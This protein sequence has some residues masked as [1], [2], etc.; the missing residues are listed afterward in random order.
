MT[1][2]YSSIAPRLIETENKI[3]IVYQQNLAGYADYDGFNY[4]KLVYQIYDKK[5]ES[6]SEVYVLDDNGYADG[7]FDVWTDGENAAIVYTQLDRRLNSGNE[8]DIS[9]YVAALEVKTAHL[10]DGRFTVGGALTDDAY[11]DLSPRIGMVDGKL[12]ALWVRCE[13]NNMLG[14]ASEEAPSSVMYSQY[15]NGAWSEAVAAAQDLDTVCS[16]E[17]C[18]DSVIYIIDRNNDLL[19]A[20]DG[21]DSTGDRCVYTCS[22]GGGS[23][24]ALAD[25]A[26][27]G[28]T[29][30]DGAPAYLCEN[31]LYFFDGTP[32]LAEGTALPENYRML[33]GEDGRVRAILYTANTEYGEDRVGSNVYGIF[34]DGDRFGSPV[35]LT[36]LGADVFVS[37]FDAA[38]MGE[39]MLLSILT[40]SYDYV[41][42]GEYEQYTT[43]N[44]FDVCYMAYPCGYTLGNISYMPEGFSLDADITAT[45]EITNN[46]I[47]ALDALP[48]SV[49]RGNESFAVTLDG[50][51]DSEGN[52]IGDALP[53]GMT[54]YLR[55]RFAPEGAS[56]TPY[57][58]KVDGAEYCINAW[59]SDLAVFGK[60][61]IVGGQHR[62]IV[63]VTNLGY[64]ESAQTT[65][66][67]S[68]SDES[69][70]VEPLARGE[71]QYFT[72]PIASS[73]ADES[74]LVTLTLDADGEH[75]T[76][77]NTAQVLT[78]PSADI[79]HELGT[80]GVWLS[81]S[82]CVIDRNRMADITI[83]YDNYY[84]VSSIT[85]DGVVYRSDSGAYTLTDGAILLSGAYFASVLADGTY[86][87][88]V[89]FSDGGSGAYTS[90]TEL[91]V[92][93]F[94]DVS[95]D[96]DGDVSVFRTEQGAMPEIPEHVGKRADAQYTYTFAGW[97]ADGDGAADVLGAAT[98][99]ISYVAIYTRERNSYTVTWM[100]DGERYREE[101]AYGELPVF[102][103]STE[104]HSDVRVYDF[105]GWSKEITAV[106]GNVTYVAEYSAYRFGDYDRD[107]ALS[108]VD[109]TMLVRYLSG[110]NMEGIHS[111]NG[112][113]S[114]NNRDAIT[115]IQKLSEWE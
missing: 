107:G 37:S 83:E 92:T 105:A 33:E 52:E 63:N 102:T 94:Y 90:E 5:T 103:G 18:G 50:Y 29:E 88:S 32:V 15:D 68:A 110:F 9:D 8:D 111:I 84:T 80:L 75:V 79:Y 34:R 46:G 38:D 1:S 114:I 67:V 6:F 108:N 101:Y 59:E 53:S 82:E 95:F 19:T 56:S 17:L 78:S 41:G 43:V 12:T 93:R 60:H 42:G 25:G 71:G 44:T 26:Y 99:D 64:I 58:V 85:V 109:L 62:V 97:D 96:V 4:Q 10:T 54:G 22:L 23:S 104:K 40:T 14:L 76:A 89:S 47:A 16:L 21:S 70:I 13:N 2:A 31:A 91:A 113:G 87:V 36:D 73:Q 24:V 115:L 30:I 48:V 49:S 72:I 51:F 77:N 57:N 74:I 112:D 98:A 28:I 11:Y 100:V 39:G 20:E 61:V 55:I 66:S 27:H 7:A 35:P 65:L 106:E 81:A 45:V 3:Y 69:Y 86:S